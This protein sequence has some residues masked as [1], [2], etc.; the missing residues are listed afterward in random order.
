MVA[1][2]RSYVLVSAGVPVG[3]AGA[4][5]GLIAPATPPMAPPVE[6]FA[7]S[8][9]GFDTPPV[10]VT[11]SEDPFGA[12]P[13]T[14]DLFS[15]AGM[16]PADDAMGSEVSDMSELP[17]DLDLSGYEDEVKQP[18]DGLEIEAANSV[19]EVLPAVTEVKRRRVREAPAVLFLTALGAG[20][21]Y[22][23][24]LAPHFDILTQTAVGGIAGL[25]AGWIVVRWMARQQ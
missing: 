1:R 21:A 20:L 14:A 10:S 16:G 12:D 9:T 19:D 6:E 13:E 17:D 18:I 22:Y 3:V 7:V 23:S 5:D 15:P 11:A 24:S 4:F 8:D 2:R 25:L